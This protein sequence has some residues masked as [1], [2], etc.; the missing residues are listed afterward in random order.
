MK[1]RNGGNEIYDFI[2]EISCE[3]DPPERMR[4]SR[5]MLIKMKIN[6]PLVNISE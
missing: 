1:E 4:S 2:T 6:D 5:V 3:D